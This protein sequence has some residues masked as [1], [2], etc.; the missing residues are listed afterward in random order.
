LSSDHSSGRRGRNTSPQVKA[1]GRNV[2]TAKPEFDTGDSGVVAVI[3]NGPC[4]CSGRTFGGTLPVAARNNT[5]APIEDPEEEHFAISLRLGREIRQQRPA[6]K[7][8][9][10]RDR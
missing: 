9:L 4:D 5:D 1:K 10:L 6:P 2:G 8:V 3:E 7:V